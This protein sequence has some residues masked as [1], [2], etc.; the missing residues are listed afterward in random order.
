MCIRFSAQGIQ[1]VLLK[2]I[3]FIADS[4]LMIMNRATY[5][6]LFHERTALASSTFEEG[7]SR[8]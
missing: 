7:L 2:I 4:A 8:W 3:Y 6:R 1:C 5:L